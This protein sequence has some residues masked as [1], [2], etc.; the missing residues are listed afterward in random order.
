MTE[1]SNQ[2]PTVTASEAEASLLH[3]HQVAQRTRKIIAQGPASS[4][5][6]LW[7]CIWMVG[8]GLCEFRP[9][10]ASP[11]WIILDAIGGI[12]SFAF[13]MR[14]RPPVTGG[15]GDVRIGIFWLALFAYAALWIWLLDPPDFKRSAAY[16]AT[17]A[18]FGYVVGGLWLSRFFVCL[19]L[20]VT[21]LTV[22]GLILFPEHFYLWMALIAGGSLILSGIYIRRAWK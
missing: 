21:A 10:W 16:F 12:A 5:L 22:L 3:I 17:V 18:M 14:S 2:N 13:G 7:G 20:A 4:I 15:R 9:D 6:M 19:G 8:Y 11:A 1:N